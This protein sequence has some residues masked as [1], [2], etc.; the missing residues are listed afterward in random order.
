[1][2]ICVRD[3]QGILDFDGHFELPWDVINPQPGRFDW[4]GYRRALEKGERVH[5]GLLISVSTPDGFADRSPRWIGARHELPNSVN[6]PAYENETWRE[7]L[8]ELILAFGEEFNGKPASVWI[9]IGIDGELQPVKGSR[10]YAYLRDVMDSGDLLDAHLLSL[11]W[12][13][14]AFPD[15][16]LLVQAGTGFRAA[17]NIGAWRDRMEIMARAFRLGIG[18]KMNGLA[19][20]KPN[21]VGY[22]DAA[23]WEVYDLADRCKALGLPVAFEPAH[24]MPDDGSDP[25]Q[26][27]YWSLHAA[28]IHGADFVSLQKRWVDLCPHEH[29]R[30]LQRLTEFPWVIFREAE[31]PEV[32]FTNTGLGGDPGFWTHGT[33]VTVS[34]SYSIVRDDSWYGRQAIEISK[35]TKVWVK[36]RMG[37]PPFRVA[38]HER[39]DGYWF[40]RE[41]VTEK[42]EVEI[43]GPAVLHKIEFHPE[44]MGCARLLLSWLPSRS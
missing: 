5:F 35:G 32:E 29:V 7:A 12:F 16:P 3:H 27:R 21:A 1:M 6:V 11:S 30:E 33:A 23:G 42:A 43:S 37:Q 24:Q 31:F 19:P 14:E 15:T 36:A 8:R 25:I 20:D 18:Y 40:R 2:R 10:Y 4:S 26:W 22:K 34:G 38:I 41:I 44:A 17:W 9:G 39:R 28:A 13:R